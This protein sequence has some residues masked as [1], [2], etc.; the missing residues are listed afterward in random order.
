M[1]SANRSMRCFRLAPIHAHQLLVSFLLPTTRKG[2]GPPENELHLCHAVAKHYSL[3]QCVHFLQRSLLGCHFPTKAPHF[4]PQGLDFIGLTAPQHH[5]LPPSLTLGSAP[6]HN[7]VASLG[8]RCTN[9]RFTEMLAAAYICPS[10]QYPSR[11]QQQLRLRADGRVGQ[12]FRV[13]QPP[14]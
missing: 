13:H 8:P 4:G 7:N 12:S 3:N 14:L 9:R 5:R 11:R 6:C 2:R 10:E 1:L